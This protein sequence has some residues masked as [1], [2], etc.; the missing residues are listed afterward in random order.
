MNTKVYKN[1]TTED[2]AIVYNNEY[3][4]IYR[5]RGP[6]FFELT[7]GISVCTDEIPGILQKA[8]IACS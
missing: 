3:I 8:G 2:F 6:G 5:F 4:E 7:Q 1:N